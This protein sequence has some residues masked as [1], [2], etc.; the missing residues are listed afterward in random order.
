[1]NF[2]D[3]ICKDH[4]LVGFVWSVISQRTGERYDIVLNDFGLTCDCIGHK[5]HGKCKH[6]QEV[7]DRLVCD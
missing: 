7:H 2:P 3:L 6:V 1:M 5:R 4:H